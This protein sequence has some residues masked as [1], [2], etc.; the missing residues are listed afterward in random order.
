[1]RDNKMFNVF[2]AMRKKHKKQ[3]DQRTKMKQWKIA[4]D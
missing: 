3:T 4:C 2:K 1:M